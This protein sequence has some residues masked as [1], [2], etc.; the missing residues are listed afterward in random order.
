MP[1]DWGGGVVSEPEPES[2]SQHAPPLPR[3]RPSYRLLPPTHLVRS[4]KIKLTSGVNYGPQ[5][6]GAAPRVVRL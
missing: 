5:F 4:K 2:Q 1:E 6:W 3:R